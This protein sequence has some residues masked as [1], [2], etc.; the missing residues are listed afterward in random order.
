[1]RGELYNI[2]VGGIQKK[3]RRTKCLCAMLVAVMLGLHVLF[4]C[5]RT[6]HNHSLMLWLNIMADTFGSWM[7]IYL[8][9][10]RIALLKQFYLFAKK[11]EYQVIG[12]VEWISERTVRYR[13]LDCYEV[14]INGKKYYAPA[15]FIKLETTFNV[16][17]SVTSGVIVEVA[18]E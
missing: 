1:M 6:E 8:Y 12:T 4:L 18:Y 17:I 9:F 14:F 2:S 7:L 5:I 3:I 13:Q 11:R 15:D 10:S 16:K